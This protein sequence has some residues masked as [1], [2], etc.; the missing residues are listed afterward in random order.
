MAAVPPV[1]DFGWKAI[2]ATLPGID[3]K[4]HSIFD[5]KGP[6]WAGRRLHLQPLPLCEGG[7][8]SHRA[9]RERS[10]GAWHRLRG[11][12]LER[13]RGLSG[14]FLRQH[15]GCLPKKHGFSFP[16]LYD[17]DQSVARAYGAACTPDFFGFNRNSSCN[18]AAGSTPRARSAGSGDPG[19]TSTRRWWGGQHRPRARRADRLDRLLDQVERGRM[20]SAGPVGRA[21]SCSI[22]TAR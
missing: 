6:Q 14:G 2:D 18:I 10:E 20:S 9:R 15:E 3:G 13:R 16:Y 8:R 22:S 19:A 12:Q 4:T 7:D 17:E 5:E 11:D 1:C 21:P